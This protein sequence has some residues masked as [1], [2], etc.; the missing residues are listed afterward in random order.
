M[1]DPH[2]TLGR[3]LW[4]GGGQWAGKSTVAH[5][6][7]RRYGLTAYHYDFHDARGHDAR[8]LAVRV[9]AGRPL[10]GASPEEM[11]VQPTPQAMAERALADFRQ[12]WA[13]VLD[14]LG[15]LDSP[16][17]VIAEGWGLRP[18]LVAPLI[19]SPRRMVVLVATE[20]FRQVQLERMPRAQQLSRSAEISDPARAQANRLARD[21][22]LAREAAEQA[23][24][25]GIRVIEVDGSRDG[26]GVA[27]LV[28]EVFAPYLPL[29]TDAALIAV[30]VQNDFCP[31]GALAVPGGDQVV[32]AI[33]ALA[34]R[35]AHV[36][37]TCDCHPADHC[38]FRHRGGPWPAHCV[39]GTPGAALRADL[40]LPGATVFRKGTDP[41]AEAYSGFAGR[42]EGGAD[43]A[44]WLRARAVRHVW[45]AGL[46]T[47]YCVRATALDALQAGFA[48][49]VVAD[50]CRA[51]DV[52]PGDGQR[53]LAE[54]AA[55]GVAVV[56]SRPD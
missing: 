30:D 23:R 2:G 43:L 54:L 50:A 24:S 26:E 40:D 32:P 56:S 14:D 10:E 12:R 22:L 55:A 19:D 38:S 5:L 1:F 46:A 25:L 51:V 42:A 8:R 15:G 52:R 18:E 36:A 11:W 35:F 4:I 16:R 33:N 34:G 47:D 48:V 13:W 27:G 29:G 6:L 39:Q 20:A 9:R 28:T 21:A 45:V 44:G 49:T 37:L 31:G 3:A 53:A 41:G 7:A 17:P